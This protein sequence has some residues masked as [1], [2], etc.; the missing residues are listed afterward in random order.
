MAVT[1]LFDVTGFLTAVASLLGF[2]AGT[3]GLLAGGLHSSE[4]LGTGSDAIA[5]L[6]IREEMRRSLTADAA[7]A[8][9]VTYVVAIFA[10]IFVLV[11][12]CPSLMRVIYV[13]S[14]RDGRIGHEKGRDWNCLSQ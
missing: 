2:D 9:A 3:A 11:Q 12:A 5:G 13:R 4:A 1:F 7:V 14:A 8:Y 10:G 6:A